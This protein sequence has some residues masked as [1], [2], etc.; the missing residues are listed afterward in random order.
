MTLHSH[1]VVREAVE[2]YDF[3]AA[4]RILD[5]GG[6]RGHFVAE[7]LEAHPELEGAVFDVPEVA[8]ST[9]DYLRSRGLGDRCAALGGDFFESLPGGYDLHIL[10]WILHDWNDESCRRLLTTC[11][12]ALPDDGRLLVVEQLLPDEVPTAGPLHP[13]IAMDLIML[14]NFADARERDL[15]EYEELLESTGF[16]VHEVV[17]LPSGFSILDCRML[18]TRRR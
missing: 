2:H 3:A 8:E 17:P 16:A 10:K 18:A 14:V 7:V 12:A 15:G 11:R 9:G 4:S 13:A 5:V 1:G 6:G